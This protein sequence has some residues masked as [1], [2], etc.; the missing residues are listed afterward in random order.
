MLDIVDTSNWIESET[1]QRLE[2]TELKCVSRR[3]SDVRT[4]NELD[5][6]MDSISP[7]WFVK[8]K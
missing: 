1:S 3:K 2:T 4:A 7:Q 6:L 5:L 8:L